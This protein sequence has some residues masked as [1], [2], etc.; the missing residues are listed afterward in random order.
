[1]SRTLLLS[2]A[3]WLLQ[4]GISFGQESHIFGKIKDAKTYEPIFGANVVVDENHGTVTDFDGNFSIKL[5]PG[6]YRITF[7]YIGYET[8]KRNVDLKDGSFREF[9]ISLEPKS[10]QLDIIVISA[11]QYEKNVAE[12][13]VSME[14]IRSELIS[15]TNARDLGE[16]IAKTPGVQVQDAQITIRGGSS[17]SYGVGTRT[18]VLVDGQNFLSADLSEAQLKFAP[19]EDVEQVEVIKGAASVIYGSSALN[20]VIN[21]RTGWPKT[22]EKSTAL[23]FYSGVYNNPPREELSW[24][25]RVNGFSG[26]FFNHRQ[27]INNLQLMVGGN[28]D[29]INSYLEKND[30]F[31]IRG[32][33]KTR[34]TPKKNDRINFGLNGNVMKEVS[35]RFFISQD[36]DS[37]AYLQGAG[38]GDEYIRT[39]LDPHFTYQNMDGHRLALRFRYL[40]IFRQGNPAGN[41]RNAISNNFSFDPQYQ[42]NWDDR[43]ILTTGLPMVYG[44]SVSN[45]YEERR[46]T[47]L[48]AAYAQGEFKI[49]KLSLV[50][51]VRYELTKVDTVFE[52]ALPVF[53]FGANYLFGKATYLRASWGQGYRLASVAERFLAQEFTNN[54]FVLPNPLLEVEKGWN[55]E[56]GVK[57][58]LKVGAWKG[59]FDA[60]VFWSQYFDFVEYRFGFYPNYWPSGEKIIDSLADNIFSIKP[61]NVEN[62]RIFGWEVSLVGE[63]KIGP[64]G[65]ATLAGYTYVYPGDLDT[66]TTQRDVG[67]FLKNAFRYFS[68]FLG[69]TD[70]AAKVLQFRQ[71]HMVRLDIE[72]TYKRF[73]LGTSILYN[74]FFERIPPEF[75]LAIGIIDGSIGSG[76]PNTL[77]QYRLDHASGDLVAD[78]RFSYRFS[79]KMKISFLMRNIANYEY[80][81]RPGKLDP[82]RT[83]TVQFALKL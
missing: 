55:L 20:G 76:R 7:S 8:V 36:L 69:G 6:N 11:S 10:E 45:L 16:V 27:R 39:A 65:I 23:T 77:D 29:Y 44:T 22:G 13:T 38:S 9:N 68:D 82:P 70:D 54:I 61:F 80:A 25:S 30:E 4:T 60:S 75:A 32:S 71:R 66:D 43:F 67:V 48:A 35:D 1:M 31:R 59:F 57:Q 62:S 79:D 15:N 51:G 18:A 5:P 49:Q 2:I 83:Y 21:M 53:R 42:K 46:N 74:S 81:V 24:T 50:G 28:I 37:N 72:F 3:C 58:G 56:V 64:I 34:Y 40:N 73:A 78:M 47:L 33:F 41:V 14:V 52:K 17:Y 63:G 26:M 19:L 12:E